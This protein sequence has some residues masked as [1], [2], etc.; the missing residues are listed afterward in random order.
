MRIYKEF[1]FEAAHFLPSAPEGHPNSRIHGHSFRVRISIDGMP[2]A[3]TGLIVHF[4]E[5][6]AAIA[7]ARD[8]LDHRLLNEVEGLEKPTLEHI[9]MWL[10]DRLDN[11]LPGLAEV[12]IFRDS[13]HEGCLYSGP[14]PTERPL[15]AE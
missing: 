6:E 11:R 7:D 10:W 9:T 5:L 2:G 13:C 8:A 15:A 1:Y 3:D 14:R 12:G 4:D